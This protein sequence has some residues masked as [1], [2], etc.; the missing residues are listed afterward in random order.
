MA[1]RSLYLS[2]AESKSRF[3]FTP[4]LF[5]L[6]SWSGQFRAD[7]IP[8][9]TRCPE[10]PC[11]YPFL[12]EALYKANQPTLFMLDNGDEVWLWQGWWPD[13]PDTENTVTGSSKL[14]WAA[15]RRCALETVLDYCRYK[16]ESDD[17][18]PPAAHL[19]SAGLEPLAFTCLFP[20]WTVDDR[21]AQLNVQVTFGRPLH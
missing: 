3:D 11:P 1:D 10:L 5:H 19:I 18:D 20:E 16:Q 8:P 7:E 14:R 12:Q 13:L 2:L 4:R 21:V 6:T 15:E 9:L 17:E